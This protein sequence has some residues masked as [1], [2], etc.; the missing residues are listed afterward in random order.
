MT[1]HR[2]DLTM[3]SLDRIIAGEMDALLEALAA[4]DLD[5]RLAAALKRK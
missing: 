4:H 1:D 2:I 3:Y 5:D